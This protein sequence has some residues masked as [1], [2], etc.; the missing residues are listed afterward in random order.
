MG[1]SNKK[2][3]IKAKQHENKKAPPPHIVI[4]LTESQISWKLSWPFLL[5]RIETVRERDWLLNFSYYYMLCK[6]LSFCSNGNFIRISR[7]AEN[8]IISPCK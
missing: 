5:V 4:T 3:Q 6:R 8:V 7:D 2:V 1:E